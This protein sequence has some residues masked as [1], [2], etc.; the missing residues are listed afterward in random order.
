M[1]LHKKRQGRKPCL[2]TIN[3]SAAL[4][5][6]LFQCFCRYEFRNRSS[7]NLDF[8]SGLGIATRSGFTPGGFEAAETS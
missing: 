4:F 1:W 6:S 3:G 5:H 2:N 7:F 8:S